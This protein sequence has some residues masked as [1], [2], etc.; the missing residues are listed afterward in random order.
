MVL[1]LAPW[2]TPKPNS[3]DFVQVDFWALWLLTMVVV[4]LPML[5]LEIALARRSK[6]MPFIGLEDLTRQ[7]DASTKW[8]TLS[9]LSLVVTCLIC[10]GLVMLALVPMLSMLQ[11]P[12]SMGIAFAVLVVGVFL[13]SFVGNKLIFPATLL[14]LVAVF[15]SGIDASSAWGITA[16]TKKEWMNAVLLGLTSSGLGLGLMWQLSLDKNVQNKETT[17]VVLPIWIGQIIV[18]II[19]ALFQGI[20]GEIAPYLYVCAS[21]C[22]AAIL[23]SLMVENLKTQKFSVIKANV[24]VASVLALSGV[25]WAVAQQSDANPMLLKIVGLLSLLSAIVYAVFAGWHMKI[26]HLRKAIK[27]NAETTYNIWRVAVRIV[28]PLVIVSAVLLLVASFF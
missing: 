14:A 16:I 19:F 6:K 11:I 23:I 13:M 8:R 15:I 28:I 26:S 3:S 17:M 10:G 20:N 9:W 7:S 25:V 4:A 18:G 21:V 1:V 2:F 22:A 24:I 12:V 27:F 5:Y